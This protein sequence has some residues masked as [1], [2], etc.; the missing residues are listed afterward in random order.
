M[1]HILYFISVRLNR[2]LPDLKP[3]LPIEQNYLARTF[4]GNTSQ[5][6]VVDF[7]PPGCL[8]VLDP[9]IDSDN[10]LLVPLLRD[11]A[12]LSNTSIIL[13][14]DAVSLPESL[15]AP[16]PEHRWCY[17]FEKADLARQFGDWE[18]VVKLGDKAF[19]LENDSPND[20]VERFV[21]I[22]GY[23][24]MGDWRR[25]VELSRTSYRVSKDYVG[26]LLC[27]LWERIETEFTG[28][29][30]SDALTGEAVSKRSEALV[31]IQHMIACHL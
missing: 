20:P 22:E 23:A 3:G 30:E 4:H 7:S 15:F 26:P 8:R 16:E 9:Q 13:A 25:A 5:L 19:K 17:Y 28:G 14:E 2:G 1:D 6:V 18:E 11:A 29:P 21:F 24:H 10:K 27:K 12:V 31:E